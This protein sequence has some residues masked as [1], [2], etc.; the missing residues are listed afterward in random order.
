[1]KRV[2]FLLFLLSSFF[3]KSQALYPGNLMLDF[4]G[5]FPNFG[6]LLVTSNS[7][8]YQTVSLRGM[9]PSGFRGEY[10]IDDNIGFGF[11]FMY[12]YVDFKYQTI[13]TTWLGDQMIFKTDDI[14]SIM[15]RMRIQFRINYHFEHDNPRF[16]SYF[17]IGA[18]YNTRTF[19]STKNDID[20]TEDFKSTIQL[21][22]L[23]ISARVCIGGR[24]YFSQYVGVVGEV[25]LGGPLVSL[26]IALKY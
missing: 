15:K 4:Y 5:G 20:N 2:V 1:M 11:D 24:Y 17:G 21:I 14:H 23:P 16:D 13:D 19:S 8:N 22:P 18:G 12:N 6:K 26:G 25:G 9:A 3:V 7:S 10:L